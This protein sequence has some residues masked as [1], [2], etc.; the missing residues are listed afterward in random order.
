MSKRYTIVNMLNKAYYLDECPIILENGALTKDNFE[1]KILLQL[2][3]KNISS[4]NIKAINIS[5]KCMDIINNELEFI[6]E[7]SYLDLDI[8]QNEIFGSNTPIIITNSNTRNFKIK[9]QKVIF[10]DSTIYENVDNKEFIEIDEQENIDI[11]DPLEMQYIKELKNISEADYRYKVKVCENYWLCSCGSFN[12]LENSRCI[13]C[14]IK[15]DDLI[16]MSNPNVLKEHLEEEKNKILEREKLEAILKIKRKKKRMVI[17]IIAIFIFVMAIIFNIYISTPLP[18]LVEHNNINKLKLLVNIG[19]DVNMTDDNGNT[20]LYFAVKSDNLE[21]V[22]FLLDNGA[23]ANTKDE[24]ILQIAYDK[25]NEEMLNLL[26]DNGVVGEVEESIEFEFGYSVN[27]VSVYNSQRG[28]RKTM[29]GK[30]ITSY[31]HNAKQ[32]QVVFNNF[33]YKGDI[34]DNKLTGK[35][36]LYRD[37]MK[38]YEGGWDNGLYSGKGRIYWNTKKNN[39]FLEGNFVNGNPTEYTRYYQDGELND[40]GTV[41]KDGL[42]NSSKHGIKQYQ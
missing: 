9:I 13:S 40:V 25:N 6:E 36:T 19:K 34:V 23:K 41:S 3:F 21:L 14:G 32:V 12:F 11:N 27:E 18:K 35:G 10:F 33:Y 31:G 30:R 39:L 38:I 24:S 29:S 8:K 28:N 15:R 17:S 5:I 1:N 42:A 22:K 20:S 4:K 2:K 7:F 37:N 26:L 16:A